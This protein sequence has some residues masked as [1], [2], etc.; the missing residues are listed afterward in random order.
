MAIDV[1]MMS[2][3]T[4]NVVLIGVIA[5]MFLIDKDGLINMLKLRIK[6]GSALIL[7][8]GKDKKLYM[9]TAQI[10]GKKEDT[11]QLV[12]NKLP[13]MLDKQKI[14]YYRTFPMLLYDEGVTEPIKI[15]SGTTASGKMTPEMLNQLL[16]TAR[17]SGQS[18]TTENRE[19]LMFFLTIGACAGACICCAMLFQHMTDFGTLKQT[20]TAILKSVRILLP[21]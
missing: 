13:Y 9:T 15:E 17:R 6:K 21:A 20:A 2:M 11:E 7:L 5:I 14:M 16:A 8:I 12:I 3:M 4:T 1:V 18:P 19:K 10:S